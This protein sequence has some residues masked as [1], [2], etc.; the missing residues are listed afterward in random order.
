[1][2]DYRYDIVQGTDE[3]LAERLGRFTG[4]DFHVFLGNSQTKKEKLWE[5]VAEHMFGDSDREEYST[6]AMER[7][8][9][10]EIEARKI[11]SMASEED[12]TEVGIVIA[13]GDWK[14]YVA[15]S[16]DGLVGKD[17][18]IEIKCLP[19]DTEV[20]TLAGYKKISQLK[21]TDFVCE[22]SI[23]GKLSWRKPKALIKK[24]Y[25]GDLEAFYR[26]NKLQL[27]CTPEHRML[28]AAQGNRDTPKVC[29]AK[30]FNRNCYGVRFGGIIHGKNTLSPLERLYIAT[31]A[32]GS[33]QHK[34]LCFNFSKDRKIKRL[35]DLLEKSSIAVEYGT[36]RN[37]ANPN[38]KDSKYFYCKDE[39]LIKAKN[40]SFFELIPIESVNTSTALE[41]IEEFCMWDG[42]V[43]KNG[44]RA[45]T[46]KNKDDVDYLQAICCIANKKSNITFV[47]KANA[48]M[49][50]VSGYGVQ[51]SNIGDFRQ[52]SRNPKYPSKSQYD[53]YVYCVTTESGF[54]VVR[55]HLGM[56][57]VVGNCPLS[58]NFLA[59]TKRTDDGY[60]EVDYIK[61]EYKTQVQFNLFVTDR[62][63]CDFIYY[64]PRSSIVVK[65]IERD[66]EYIQKIKDTLDECIKFVKE[67]LDG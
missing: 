22:C 65:R 39:R 43:G 11:Y 35:L 47:K 51:S 24:K 18:I 36:T 4:S 34:R 52:F 49:L 32:D 50:T 55:N 12:V 28:Y 64:H 48:Y 20:L 27:R 57:I 41:I 33:I 40:T 2:P 58:K 15:C 13:D 7:G 61:P 1:M 67:N 8:H 62:Q 53:G 6:F 21:M 31:K 19:E 44:I 26:D 56:N 5:K 46:S 38:W 59:W 42:T 54:F 25:S 60:R 16:P 10:L 23:D 63:W 17:G 9:I 37:F 30:D 3:W 14:N 29:E 45:F 66:E